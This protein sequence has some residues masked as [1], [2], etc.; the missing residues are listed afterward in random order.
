MTKEQSA[1]TKIIN[2]LRAGFKIPISK[3]VQSQADPTFVNFIM[4]TQNATQ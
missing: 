4:A 2:P 1:A 3:K